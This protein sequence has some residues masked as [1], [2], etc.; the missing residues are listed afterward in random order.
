MTNIILIKY[1]DLYIKGRNKKDFISS[2]NKNIKI[3]LSDFKIKIKIEFDKFVLTYENENYKNEIINILKYIPGISFIIPCKIIKRDFEVLKKNIL[4]DLNEKG[5][6]KIEVKRKDKS[7]NLDSYTLKKLIGSE[8]LKSR[9]YYFVDVHNP[10]LIIYIEVNKNNFI[11]YTNK[12]KG[13]SGLPIGLN[14]RALVLLSG[15]I[16]SPVA[17]Y[18]LQRKGISVDYITFITPPHTNEQSLDKVKSLVKKITLNNKINKSS[19][20]IVNLTKIMNEISHIKL[21]SY[22]IILMRR[23]FFKIASKVS[24]NKNYDFIAT[25]DSLGQVA[26]QTI[27]SIKCTSSAID[28][29]IIIRPLITFSK[30]EII[31]IAK[32]IGTYEISILP[33]DDSCSM[34]V[35]KNPIT[36]PQI[37]KT[38]ELEQDLEY[39]DELIE[40]AIKEMIRT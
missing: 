16:D 11:Y 2:L 8:I 4:N 25:G 40:H 5:K 12:I 32:F 3:A 20:Y 39:L 14:G 31:D 24:K 18:L 35:P 33:Y 23:V 37:K 29:P 26:S 22:K 28:E 27:Q 6:F 21:E 1:G 30:N 9:K 7:Y 17:G 10:D 34:F 13:I 36:K 38:I 19:L 15:G